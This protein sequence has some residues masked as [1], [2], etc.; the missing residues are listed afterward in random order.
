[1]WIMG[2][3]LMVSLQNKLR[4][5]VPRRILVFQVIRRSLILIFLGIVINSSKHTLV[6]SELRLPGV[7]QRLGITYFIVGILEI[8]FTKRIELEVCYMICQ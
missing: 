6:I 4:R 2:L 1:M 7:L 5:S 3:S 8:T